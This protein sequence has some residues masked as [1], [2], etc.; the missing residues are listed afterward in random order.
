MRVDQ[1][2]QHQPVPGAHEQPTGRFFLGEYQGL[3]A[4][5]RAFTV[6]PTLANSGS[7]TNRTDI[8]ARTVSPLFH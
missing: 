1:L 4:A 7:L 2:R 6:V 5:G 8:Y 3:E